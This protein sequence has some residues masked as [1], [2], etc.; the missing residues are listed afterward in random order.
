MN[1]EEKA[2]VIESFQQN[3]QDT[4]S[5]EVQVGLLTKKIKLLTVH[6]TTH[7]KDFSTRRGLLNMVSRRKTFLSYLQKRVGFTEYAKIVEMLGLRK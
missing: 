4:G 5:I 3:A 6:C 7:P 1:K 2:K